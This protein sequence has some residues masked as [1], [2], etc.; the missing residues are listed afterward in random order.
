MNRT[1]GIKINLEL[2]GIDFELSNV[3]S[4]GSWKIRGADEPE[5]SELTRNLTKIFNKIINNQNKIAEKLNQ[6]DA[7]AK[8]NLDFITNVWERVRSL[9]E[10]LNKE[11]YPKSKP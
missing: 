4:Y 7:K 3:D 8:E 10:E 11:I 9:H 2:E 5:P 6:L 1:G